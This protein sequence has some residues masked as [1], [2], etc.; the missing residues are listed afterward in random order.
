MGSK[1]MLG[2]QI[3]IVAFCQLQKLDHDLFSKPKS[4]KNVLEVKANLTKY[5]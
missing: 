1:Y 4:T 2:G 3:C 5:T